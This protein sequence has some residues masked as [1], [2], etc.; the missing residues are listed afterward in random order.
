MD[1]LA[2]LQT[3]NFTITFAV[4]ASSLSSNPLYNLFS[5]IL[6][7]EAASISDNG[8]KSKDVLKGMY[9]LLQMGTLQ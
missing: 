7:H 4:L 5:L 9:Y 3:A 2:G 1:V 8:R 6:L